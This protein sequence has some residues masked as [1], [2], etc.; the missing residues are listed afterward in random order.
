MVRIMRLV[1]VIAVIFVVAGSGKVV[2]SAS[3]DKLT[4]DMIED[5][6][7]DELVSLCKERGLATTGTGKELRERLVKFVSAIPSAEGPVREKEGKETDKKKESISSVST[8]SKK[9]EAG[10]L[11]T[12]P[13]FEQ[14]KEE[15]EMESPWQI[16]DTEG[17]NGPKCAV[18]DYKGGYAPLFHSKTAISA[19]K[20]YK[21]SMYIRSEIKGDNVTDFIG[22]GAGKPGQP[23]SP[24]SHYTVYNP[25]VWNDWYR[26]DHYFYSG[27]FK[28]VQLSLY[29]EGKATGKIWIDDAE[30]IEITD[31]QLNE[32]LVVNPDFEEGEDNGWPFGW[33]NMHAYQ[34][35]SRPPAIFSLDASAGYINGEKSLKIDCKTKKAKGGGVSGVSVLVIPGKKYVFSV[36]AKSDM[37]GAALQLA[38]EDWCVKDLTHTTTT[39]WQKY[40]ISYV[41]PENWNKRVVRLLPS[42]RSPDVLWLDEIS[43]V[44]EE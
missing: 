20:Y 26:I 42:L 25:N 8:S 10:N 7:K 30:L 37:D 22:L 18:L 32:N 29:Q 17:R 28:A 3:K 21:L 16:D 39:E 1:I 31:K 40:S 9:T 27:E 12:N 14:G 23:G 33:T 36:W 5:A 13:G 4:M 6:G 38:V 35:A 15:W 41:I 24:I 34:G 43:F 19:N 44:P 11:L 2:F